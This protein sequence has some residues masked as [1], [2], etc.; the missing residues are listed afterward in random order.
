MIRLDSGLIDELGLAALPSGEKPAFLEYIYDTLERRVGMEIAQQ[1][2]DDQLTEFEAVIDAQDEAG[3]LRFLE[4]NVPDYKQL[5]QEHF[6][7]L[8]EEIKANAEAILAISI[9]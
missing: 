4:T 2:S 7:L 1:F 5:V 8:K 9:G 6:E 3:A